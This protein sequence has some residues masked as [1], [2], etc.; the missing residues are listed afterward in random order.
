MVTELLHLVCGLPSDDIGENLSELCIERTHGA[1][2]G[3]ASWYVL[4]SPMSS[5]WMFL[6]FPL[7]HLSFNLLRRAGDQ[8]RPFEATQAAAAVGFLTLLAAEETPTTFSSST[9]YYS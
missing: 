5:D 9:F 6:Y 7:L 4:A 8:T 2:G 1:S 3:L